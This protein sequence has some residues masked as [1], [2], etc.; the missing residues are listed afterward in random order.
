MKVIEQND[1]VAFSLHDCYA[2]FWLPHYKT[3]LQKI[4]QA[5]NLRTLD[6][7]AADMT[8]RSAL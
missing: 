3:L 1:F 5:G 6:E 7:V 4:K 2:D 8:F